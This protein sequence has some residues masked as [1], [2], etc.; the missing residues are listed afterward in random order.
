MKFSKYE[1]LRLFLRNTPAAQT[2][3]TLSFP[4]IEDCAT[5]FL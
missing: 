5:S 1:G 4:Q 3:I 2:G